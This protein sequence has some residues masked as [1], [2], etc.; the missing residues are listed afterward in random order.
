MGLKGVVMPVKRLAIEFIQL[1]GIQVSYFH[2]SLLFPINSIQ[3]SLRRL[4]EVQISK[5]PIRSSDFR[6]QSATY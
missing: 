3:S 2:V 6:L 5:Q 1:S 4:R